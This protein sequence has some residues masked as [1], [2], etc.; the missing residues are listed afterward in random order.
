MSRTPWLVRI[1]TG[2]ILVLALLFPTAA[3]LA[4]STTPPEQQCKSCH[5]N[6]YYL[7]DTGRWYCQC[8]MRA[9]CT[10]CHAGDADQTDENLAHQGMVA[11]PAKDNIAACQSCHPQDYDEKIGKFLAVAGVH[12]TKILVPTPVLIGNWSV[13]S[14]SKL[15]I[16]PGRPA[17]FQPWRAAGVLL[18]ILAVTGLCVALC[19]RKCAKTPGDV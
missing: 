8:A 18:G 9:N 13:T 5:E 7:Y 15:A 4:Q 6:L 1:L 10:S 12:A 16:P 3:A 2:A 11:N 17:A 19:R 14:S